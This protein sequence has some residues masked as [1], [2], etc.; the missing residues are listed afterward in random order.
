MRILPWVVGVHG[1]VD[2]K[3]VSEI[4]DFVQIA[5]DRRAKIAEDVAMES[6][7]AHYSLHQIRCQALRLNMANA[8]T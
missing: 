8:G 2:E 6:V 1:M 7:K 3:S 5:Q 4:L